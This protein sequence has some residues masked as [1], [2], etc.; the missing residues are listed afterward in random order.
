M[1]T[2]LWV[3]HRPTEATMGFPRAIAI[4]PAESVTGQLK[5]ITSLKPEDSGKFFEY[6]GNPHPL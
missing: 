3:V 2:V 4:P 5:L 1:L 6:K